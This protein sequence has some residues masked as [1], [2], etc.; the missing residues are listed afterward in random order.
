MNSSSVMNMDCRTITSVIDCKSPET[1]RELEKVA[2]KEIGPNHTIIR[3]M[4][5]GHGEPERM[6]YRLGDYF[7]NI[8]LQ[9][10]E[11]NRLILTFHARHD[12]DSRWKDLLMAV[13]RAL[14]KRFAGIT[15]EFPRRQT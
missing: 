8:E 2:V 10:E 4:K 15:V 12:V 6:V 3:T 11:S 13:L 14:G 5:S 7:E 1:M 9:H